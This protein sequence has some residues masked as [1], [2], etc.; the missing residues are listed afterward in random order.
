MLCL[1]IARPSLTFKTYI[2]PGCPPNKLV[3]DRATRGEIQLVLG[4]VKG[5]GASLKS[6]QEAQKL[7]VSFGIVYSV[8]IIDESNTV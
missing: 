5:S 7:R 2:A 6:H 3:L 4:K 1:V 8:Y